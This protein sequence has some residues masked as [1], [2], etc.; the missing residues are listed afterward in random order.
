MKYG[1][2]RVRRMMCGVL[3]VMCLCVRAE[4]AGSRRLKLADPTPLFSVTDGEGKEFAY[5]PG[6]GRALMVVFLSPGHANSKRALEELGVVIGQLKENSQALDVVVAMRESTG[7]PA[8]VAAWK[9]NGFAGRVVVTGDDKR[10]LWG[11]FGCIAVPTVV[12]CDMAD[13]IL[14]FEAGHGYAF[15]PVIRARLNQAL[16]IAQAIKPE[17]AGKVQTAANDNVDAR[18]KRLI[19][20]AHLLSRKG[21]HDS[22]LAELK[23]AGE[24]APQSVPVL[25]GLGQMYCESMQGQQ[26][27]DVLGA[28]S[29]VSASEQAKV[30]LLTGWAQRLLNQFDLAEASLKKA[31]QLAPKE[32]RAYFELGRVYQAKEQTEL[33][34]S[35]YYRAL[36]IVFDAS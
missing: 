26:A 17:S 8:S 35:T 13:K 3:M 11:Q 24:L 20:T 32:A 22:A 34:A 18:V 4:A 25:L 15:Q 31:T 30:Y 2:E 7:V 23:K 12:I 29:K 6:Q 27:L 19:H 14:W 10:Q 36:S 33:A 28:L 21:R 1:N 5:Q 16:G 9:Q